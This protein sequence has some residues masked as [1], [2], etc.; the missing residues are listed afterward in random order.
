M[1][2]ML[3]YITNNKNEN[4][5]KDKTKSH[6][7]LL[8]NKLVESFNVNTTINTE[9]K[10]A[11]LKIP[12]L[13]YKLVDKNVTFENLDVD[14][15]KSC[16][17]NKCNSKDIILSMVSISNITDSSKELL[18][19]YINTNYIKIDE[20]NLLLKK[21]IDSIDSIDNKLFIWIL[22]TN[23]KLVSYVL[24]KYK[25]NEDDMINMVFMTA[26]FKKYELSELK[27]IYDFNV[28]I[29]DNALNDAIMLRYFK[30]YYKNKIE[31]KK[32]IF[33]SVDM[34]VLLL[35]KSKCDNYSIIYAILNNSDK[36]IVIRIQEKLDKDKGQ[37]HIH[38]IDSDENKS[39]IKNTDDLNNDINNITVDE[40]LIQYTIRNKYT[41]DLIS[42]LINKFIKDNK[43]QSD[44]ILCSYM[45]RCYDIFITTDTTDID[46]DTLKQI[47]DNTDN[48]SITEISIINSVLLTN[49]YINKEKFNKEIIT[50]IIN[51]IIDSNNID[52]ISDIV[53]KIVLFNDNIEVFNMLI[54]N[55]VKIYKD[56]LI[57]IIRLGYEG[58]EDLIRRV[59]DNYDRTELNFSEELFKYAKV[60][61]YSEELF[62]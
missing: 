14:D 41:I 18:E 48:N 57:D 20:E 4:E 55:K 39:Y 43:F 59:I 25:K 10:N 34:L 53:I 22:Y 17:E 38:I 1:D 49:F 6:T 3:Y 47:L 19:Y 5:Y 9:L 12:S 2:I 62:E 36:D 27:Q 42:K 40:Q 29:Y 46:L 31:L 51:N 7:S 16:I 60:Y 61:G 28:E 23:K 11:I 26:L 58:T 15:I 54:E 33:N 30:K 44:S 45:D 8:I 50:K 35:D 32:T 52:K 56:I 24:Q 21:L 37:N 13:F